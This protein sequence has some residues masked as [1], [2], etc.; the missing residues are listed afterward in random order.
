MDSQLLKGIV[1]HHA[2]DDAISK[3]DGWVNLA[4][5][6]NERIINPRGW[7]LLVEFEERTTAWRTPL[8]AKKSPS[9]RNCRICK[10]S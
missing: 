2:N 4:S 9:N 7:D 3:D 8:R 5:G 10:I 1:N 6:T